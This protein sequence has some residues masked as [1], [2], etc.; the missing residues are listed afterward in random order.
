M[1]K[2]VSDDDVNNKD[3]KVRNDDDRKS[4][5]NE[6]R[7]SATSSPNRENYRCL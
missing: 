7:I 6:V 3:I 1:D 4:D 5:T 2:Y